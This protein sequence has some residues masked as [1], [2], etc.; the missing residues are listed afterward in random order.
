MIKKVL[1]VGAGPVGLL[2]AIHLTQYNI[3]V[4]IIDQNNGNSKYSKALSVTASSLKVFHGMGIIESFLLAGE[5]VE[6]VYIY[7]NKKKTAHINKK[8]LESLY[9]YYLSLPQPETE[10]ILE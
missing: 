3:L 5:T 4:K 7:F 10:K 2:L 6:S 9:N 8:Y 1:I